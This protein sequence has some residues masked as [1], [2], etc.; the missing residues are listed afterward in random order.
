MDLGI[1]GLEWKRVIG[2][3][4]FGTVHLA[5]D[6]DHG[7][8]VAVKVL[9]PLA[10]DDERR[11]FDRERRLMGQLS[12][13]P[14][15]VTIHTSGV[16]AT[17][18][19]YLVMEHVT[20]GSL[21]DRYTESPLRWTEVVEIGRS[22]ADALT[23][24]HSIGILHR[25]IKP[26]NVLIGRDDRA[27]LTDFGIAVAATDFSMRGTVSATPAFAPPELLNGRPADE[28][29]DVYS[30]A[31][32][33]HA[34]LTGDGP[35]STKGQPVLT[36]LNRIANE[37]VPTVDRPDVP[38]ALTDLLRRALDKDPDQRPP[39]MAAFATE[40]ATVADAPDPAMTTTIEGT[41][42]PP[43]HDEIEQIT[44]DDDSRRRRRPVLLTLAAAAV[45]V[46]LIGALII[47]R[48]DDSEP[49]ALGPG[50]GATSTSSATTTAPETTTATPE[51]STT[52][53]TTTTTTPTTTTPTTET[54][55]V[56]A[57]PRIRTPSNPPPTAPPPTSPPPTSPP[58][59]SPPPTSPPPTTSPLPT[60]TA[61]AVQTVAVPDVAGLGIGDARARLS[62]AGFVVDSAPA[63]SNGI[64]QTTA[65][66]PGT[67]LEPGSLVTLAIAPCIVPNYVGLRL[68][69]AIA[70]SRSID[71]LTISWPDFCDDVVLGQSIAG[72]TGVARGTNIALTLTPC[73]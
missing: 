27:M 50:T 51:T 30:L 59:T 40:L 11:R 47:G 35:Y 8:D 65:P 68:D 60:T 62:G 45:V 66:A 61:P 21:M 19:P 18:S 71:G 22:L 49:I 17:E 28:R 55:V 5:H 54:T 52:T 58:P 16:S 2:H 9:T 57:A 20:G 48:A 4:G 14:N 24:A 56:A 46:T 34:C 29:G 41:P 44:P 31:A 12:D 36:V 10:D 25:D 63:C 15:I 70:I 13:H 33:L 67:Q 39:T 64:A 26:Q 1:D 6:A 69:D 53:A 72:G 43:D 7:R 73:G 42:P 3:G 38:P 32:T 23:E 37:P